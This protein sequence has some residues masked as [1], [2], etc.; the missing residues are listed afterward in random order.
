[1][2]HLTKFLT[3]AFVGGL[4]SSCTQQ[5]PDINAYETLTATEKQKVDKVFDI[6]RAIG[7]EIDPNPTEEDYRYILSYSIEQWEEAAKFISEEIVLNPSIIEV[8]NKDFETRAVLSNQDVGGMW[9]CQIDGQHNSP[10]ISSKEIMSIAYSFPSMAKGMG[11]KIISNPAI[12]W[13]TTATP[14]TSFQYDNGRSAKVTIS[15]TGKYGPI[16]HSATA[17]GYITVRE[18]YTVV[19]D[20]EITDFH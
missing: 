6:F 8:D 4:L 11:I 3:I 15:G 16:S 2:K 13:T 10:F 18:G 1:M 20:G 17:V 5:T 19:T 12:K 9:I 7:S 14:R